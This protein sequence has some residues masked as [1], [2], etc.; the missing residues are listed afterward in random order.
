MNKYPSLFSFVFIGTQNCKINTLPLGGDR[1]II[2]KYYAMEYSL[3][4]F[5]TN[6]M[7]WQAPV[8]AVTF[9]QRVIHTLHD[10]PS[11]LCCPDVLSLVG[12]PLSGNGCGSSN[13]V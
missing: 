6:V 12:V 1:N 5:R 8:N 4:L 11:Y 7:D 10:Y 2:A 9:L 13:H 3:K